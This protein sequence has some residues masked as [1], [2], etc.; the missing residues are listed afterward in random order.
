VNH[1][2]VQ[3]TVRLLT[4]SAVIPYNRQSFPKNRKSGFF[5]VPHIEVLLE[6]AQMLE[7][8][9][10]MADLEAAAKAAQ[11]RHELTQRLDVQ[12][13]VRLSRSAVLLLL[14]LLH[15]ISGHKQG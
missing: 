11:Q 3:A 6:R 9:V 1:N 4:P 12:A 7:Q 13:T 14:H 2:N 5:G 8:D 10:A 15:C